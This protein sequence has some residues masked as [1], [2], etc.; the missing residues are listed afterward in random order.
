MHW[1]EF[2]CFNKSD[3]QVLF[4]LLGAIVIFLLV[5]YLMGDHNKDG[6]DLPASTLLREKREKNASRETQQ[7]YYYVEGRKAELFPFD[8]NTADS[9]QLLRLGLQPWQVRNI[10]R[11]RAKGGVYRKP[12]DFARLYGLTVKQYRAMEP[13]IHISSDYQDA[14]TLFAPSSGGERGRSYYD[15][16]RAD[17]GNEGKQSQNGSTAT[18]RD[19]RTPNEYHRDTLRYPIKLKPGEQI[20]LNTSD[21]TQL[22]KVPGIGSFYA[23][24]IVRY[25]ERLGGYYDVSQLME[26]EGFPENALAYFRISR[27]DIQ[28]MNVN[29]LSAAQLR[30]HPY[31]NYM[32]AKAILDYRRLK[33]PLQSMQDLRLLPDFTPENIRRIEPYIEF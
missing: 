18:L 6:D 1:K 17:E 27:N 32:M 29:K 9:T 3:R 8:P 31:I 15:D 24:K 13:Y 23:R 20:A 4:V 14:S 19:G 22:K 16:G 2:F 11:Y 7:P 10:Y 25:R 26:I 33:G 30:S 28:R 12:Q 5:T 21:T